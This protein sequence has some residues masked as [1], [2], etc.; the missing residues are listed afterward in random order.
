[1]P[2]GQRWPEADKEALRRLYAAHG[3]SWDGW[4]R[5]LSQDYG[6]NAVKSMA[7]RM[8]LRRMR[9][10]TPEDDRVLVAS[11]AD[12]CR[13][14]GRTPLAVVGRVQCLVER[15]RGRR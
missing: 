13:R 1:M 15:S 3:P 9:A 10:W 11:L 4:A 12:V 6:R 5:E 2:R 7:Q 8:G 14:L